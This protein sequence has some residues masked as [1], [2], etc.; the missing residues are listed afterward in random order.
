MVF[1]SI[2]RKSA[3][4]LS[5]LASRLTRVNRNYRSA[6]FTA[7]NYL[8]Q[9]PN[10]ST[11]LPN[12]YFSSAT[13]VRKPSSDE[14]LLRV[15]DSE[16]NC[17]EETDDHNRMEE[18]PTGFPFKIE[19]NPGQQT[20]ILTREYQGELVKV[21]VHM[22][23]LVTGETPEAVD[24]DDDMEKPNQSSIP[25]VV[26]VTKNSGTSLEFGCVAYADEIAIDSLAVRKPN[27]S[28]DQIAYEGPDFHDLDENLKKAF[29]KYL[30]IRGI[31]PSA[32][33]F[34]FEY[35]LNKD[36]REYLRWLKNLK[37]FVEA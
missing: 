33:N 6:V 37:N 1:S 19:D 27:N 26:T 23:D 25:L 20:I 13:E 35:M 34:L 16:V 18:T 7:S 28:E 8:H 4:S 5:S 11:F 24:D 21:D 32:T 12:H 10:L 14:S 9:K 3:S 29:H 30:E 36:S 15:I 2:F 17:A 22:P 31:K